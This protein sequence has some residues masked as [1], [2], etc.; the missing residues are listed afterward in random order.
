MSKGLSGVK[1]EDLSSVLYRQ[2]RKLLFNICTVS[3]CDL[4]RVKP[5][6]VRVIK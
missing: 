1:E 3:L 2:L 6:V 5:R 4:A